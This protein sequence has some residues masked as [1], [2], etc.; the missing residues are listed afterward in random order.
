MFAL[1]AKARVLRGTRFDPFGYT[2][3]RRE[4]RALIAEYESLVDTLLA[5]LDADNLE[6]AV[7]LAGLTDE[8]RGFGHIKAAAVQATRRKQQE[9]LETFCRPPVREAA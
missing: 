9:L 5:G 2:A 4:E 7:T 3:E 8:I 6:I 1:L